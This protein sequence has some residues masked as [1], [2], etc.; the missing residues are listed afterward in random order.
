MRK[1][2]SSS[3]RRIL[4]WFFDEPSNDPYVS[5]TFDVDVTPLRTF[6][7]AYQ[8][9]HG[10]RVGVQ[11][12][13]TRAVA[14]CL[15]ELPALNVKVLGGSLYAL[16]G[17]NIAVP[18]H[19][20]SEGGGGDETGMTI[21]RDVHRKSLREVAESTRATAKD[22]REGRS[23]FSGSAAARRAARFV[24]DGML[25]PALEVAR[26]IIN[27]PL[28]YG[29]LESQVGI[30][31][32]VTNVGAVFSLPQGARFRA[33]SATIPTKLGPIATLFGVG[34]TELA[35]VSVD[36]AVVTRT[37]LPIMMIVDHRAVDGVLMAKAAG[38][39]CEALL[40]PECLA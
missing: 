32:G 14:R 20:A 7:D 12:A 37:V 26:R 34:P 16:D 9:E 19:L 28:G 30:S 6:L 40:A 3:T 15:V 25:R 22:E 11:H 4:M 13:I 8:R 27:H 24:P 33:A 5:L 35:A 36:G 29:L 23:T 21:V 38:R 2:H 1:L 17:V 18:V 10:V 39:V 31:S